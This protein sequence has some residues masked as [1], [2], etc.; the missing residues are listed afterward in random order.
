MFG[1]LS[2]VLTP[3]ADG[4]VQTPTLFETKA[5]PTEYPA[6]KFELKSIEKLDENGRW[7]QYKE[8]L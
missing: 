6:M 7:I 8:M 3:I 4:A 5:D 2:L 1:E